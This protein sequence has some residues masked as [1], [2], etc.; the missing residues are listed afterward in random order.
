MNCYSL[1]DFNDITFGGFEANLPAETLAI[2]T[3]LALQVGSPTYIRTPTFQKKETRVETVDK[4]KRRGNNKGY[5]ITNDEDWETL[6]TFQVTKIEQKNGINAQ[7]VA[8]RYCL[9]TMTDQNYSKQVEDIDAL[10]EKIIEDSSNEDILSIGN[11]I[12]EFASNN[13]FYSKLYADLYTHLIRRFS[14]MK[15]IFDTNFNN[16]MELF[17]S[18]EYIDSNTDYDGFCKMTTINEKRKSV[19][20]FF[21]NLAI[22]KVVAYDTLVKI[23][24]DLL[25]R[26]LCLIK[27]ENKKNE[28]DEIFENIAIIYNKVFFEEN[29]TRLL[30]NDKSFIDTIKWVA[31]CKVKMFP[32]LSNKSI[33]KCMDLIDM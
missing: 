5:E 12:F 13:R 7:V 1:Q 31:A 11:A 4:K 19:S 32:S 21:V 8:I 2:I 16:F 26:V 9:N 10:L 15:D 25:K 27:E 23:A 30:D 33:F 14:I 28:V 6:R 22:N 29:E 20:T 3:E 17:S 24:E 18:I